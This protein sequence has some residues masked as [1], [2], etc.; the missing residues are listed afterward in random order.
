MVEKDTEDTLERVAQW[1]QILH[2]ILT[3]KIISKSKSKL[4]ATERKYKHV[5]NTITKLE[6]EKMMAKDDQN[7]LDLEEKDKEKKAECVL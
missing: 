3:A 7:A 2:K 6:R 4:V 5:V 1:H